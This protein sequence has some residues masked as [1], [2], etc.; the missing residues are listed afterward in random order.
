MNQ[1]ESIASLYKRFQKY[2]QVHPQEISENVIEK[3]E[4]LYQD[5][6]FDKDLS[7]LKVSRET[8]EKIFRQTILI[9][10]FQPKKTGQIDIKMKDESFWKTRQLT[11][12]ID[13]CELIILSEKEIILNLRFFE[14]QNPIQDNKRYKFLLLHKSLSQNFWFADDDKNYVNQWFN[15]I[16][17]CVFQGRRGRRYETMTVEPL[18][19]DINIELLKQMDRERPSINQNLFYSQELNQQKHYSIN[20][21]DNQQTFYQTEQ[22]SQKQIDQE[23]II[24]LQQSLGESAI[25]NQNQTIRKDN[26]IEQPELTQILKDLQYKLSYDYLIDESDFNLYLFEDTIRI[27]QNKNDL[28]NFR[29]YLPIT[30]ATSNSLILALYD[31]KTQTK[32]NKQIK[33]IEQLENIGLTTVKIKETREPFGYFYQPRTFNYVRQF[34]TNYN[35]I[36]VI[37]KSDDKS[38]SIIHW[39]ICAVFL[40]QHTPKLFVVDT[41]TINGGYMTQTQDLQLTIQYLKEYIHLIQYVM[42][43]KLQKQAPQFILDLINIYESRPVKSKNIQQLVIPE[44]VQNN[45]GNNY[46]HKS[47]P[48]IDLLKENEFTRQ[49]SISYLQIKQK[50]QQKFQN[51]S[52]SK[53]TNSYQIRDQDLTLIKK[54]NQEIIIQQ[55]TFM[56]QN[57]VL[58]FNVPI[59]H[60]II[61]EQKI[62]EQ[63]TETIDDNKQVVEIEEK[64]QI[65]IEDE[66]EDEIE[67]DEAFMHED[68]RPEWE[69]SQLIQNQDDFYK[70]LLDFVLGNQM[71]SSQLHP[72][73]ITIKEDTQYERINEINGFHFFYRDEWQFDTKKGYLK[74]VNAKKLEAQKKVLKYI[75]SK[76][77]SNLL[78][79][80]SILSVSLPVYVFEKRTNLQ[81][82][83]ASFAYAP[84]F[85]ENVPNDPVQQ[86]GAVIAFSLSFTIIYLNLEKPF[87]PILGETCQLWI[88]GC[89]VYLEQIS[90]HPPIAAFI[91][92]GRGYKIYGNLESTA[93]IGANTVTGGNEGKIVIECSNAKIE[94]SYCKGYVTG[95]T[96]GDRYFYTE[97]QQ[98]YV[99]HKNQIISELYFNPQKKG[100]NQYDYF[101]GKIYKVNQNILQKYKKD[102]K[103]KMSNQQAQVLAEIEGN[104]QQEEVLKMNGKTIFNLMKDFPFKCKPE[105]FPLASDSQYREDLIGWQ[106]DDFDLSMKYKEVLEERQRK[107]RKLRK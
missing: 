72:Y 78:K 32:W 13:L 39:N 58:N 95:I 33:N 75:L 37:D 17:Q 76:M 70:D 44:Y 12:D 16:K 2:Q 77:G 19:K 43:L 91:M 65:K 100:K 57:Q 8:K 96:Y 67:V 73:T 63:N 9:Y 64:K 20:Q 1:E 25:L 92:Y 35:E 87:N 22:S 88:K 31:I 60:Q 105:R 47:Q 54:Q 38:S 101:E 81:R 80:K 24:F 106:L 34:Y 11:I 28:Y 102:G 107:D 4:S 30:D 85:L 89:P 61:D 21:L 59:N 6:A 14:I 26:Q 29:I 3:V 84:H 56:E 51:Y 71:Y 99:D 86:M 74:F 66:S 52:D 104:W 82:F 103:I 7:R 5:L 45:T 49:D 18:V 50:Y 98:L 79:G 69:K 53:Q 40:Q 15:D 68:I 10:M 83:G 36:Y 62:Q 55:D 97:G 23:R 46:M 48:Q 93:S 27:M 94:Y 42:E 90:H 41:K